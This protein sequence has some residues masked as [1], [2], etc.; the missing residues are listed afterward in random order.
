MM[1]QGPRI[2]PSSMV[3]FIPAIDR[4]GLNSCTGTL[5]AVGNLPT[6]Q[7]AEAG[8]IESCYL[9][10]Y[11]SIVRWKGALGVREFLKTENPFPRLGS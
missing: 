5:D 6:L 10:T 9:T 1:S 7:G 11:G 3:R 4:F 2:I 8:E